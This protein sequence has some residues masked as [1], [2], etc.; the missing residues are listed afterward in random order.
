MGIYLLLAC[1]AILS[2]L[3]TCLIK[4]CRRMA[5]CSQL[6]RCGDARL[7]GRWWHEAGCR[8]RR[9]V[10]QSSVMASSSTFDNS[11]V[12]SSRPDM[13]AR[14]AT[15]RRREALPL[16]AKLFNPYLLSRISIGSTTFLVKAPTWGTPMMSAAGAGN[17]M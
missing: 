5:K 16:L 17:S 3:E 14:E 8:G 4:T 9:C 12:T 10:A 7:W 6:V 15:I 11:A 1:R 2:C 13:S